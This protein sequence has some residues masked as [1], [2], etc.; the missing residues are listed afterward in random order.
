[1]PAILYYQLEAK[2]PLINFRFRLKSQSGTIK[3]EYTAYKSDLRHR[4]NSLI[5]ND[6]R[7]EESSIA[8]PWLGWS[9]KIG[10]SLRIEKY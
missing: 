2:L 3:G 5:I 8:P 10:N 7:M 1:M 4:D 9:A 6:L